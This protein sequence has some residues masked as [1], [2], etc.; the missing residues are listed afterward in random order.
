MADNPYM[1]PT[2]GGNA[3]DVAK[4]A[5]VWRPGM[6]TTDKTDWVIIPVKLNAFYF[7]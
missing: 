1:P 4:G 3:A 2:I 5:K 7:T 6:S